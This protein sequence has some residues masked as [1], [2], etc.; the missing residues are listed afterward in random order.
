MLQTLPSEV[1]R[2]SYTVRC[3]AS[4]D[5]LRE[6][7]KLRYRVF[8]EELSAKGDAE[9]QIGRIDVDRF[10]DICDH[11]IV[12]HADDGIVG[13]YR[14]LR[15]DVAEKHGGFYTEGEFQIGELIKRK[16]ELR[17]VELGRSCVLKEHRTK[18][19]IDLL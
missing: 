6:A 3:A 9:A 15:Q 4:A 18:P 7:Q 2:G 5:E 19:V 1:C 13:T 12:T 16:P 10:D 17:F 11:L 14:L 8:Y